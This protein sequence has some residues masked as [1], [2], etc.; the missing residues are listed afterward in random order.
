MSMEY[1][2]QGLSLSY[3]NKR[4]YL[5]SLMVGWESSEMVKR[6]THLA[7]EHLAS[8]AANIVPIATE[9]TTAEKK[10]GYVCT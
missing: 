1:G 2:D 9:L 6:H 7:S 8:V 3:D 5:L 10:R 4:P